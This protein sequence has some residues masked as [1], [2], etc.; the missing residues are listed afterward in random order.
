MNYGVISNIRSNCTKLNILL[1][2]DNSFLFVVVVV[3]AVVVVVVVFQELT[4]AINWRVTSLTQLSVIRIFAMRKA[5]EK[6]FR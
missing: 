2:K 5:W 6:T 3:V 4:V 1:S